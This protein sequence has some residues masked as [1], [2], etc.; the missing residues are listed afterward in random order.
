MEGQTHGPMEKNR[1]RNRSITYGQRTF[2][3]GVKAIEW[4]KASFQQNVLEQ[5]NI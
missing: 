1:A 3:V 5:R 4:R 2:D